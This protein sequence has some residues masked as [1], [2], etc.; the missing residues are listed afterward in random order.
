MAALTTLAISGPAT[1]DVV[2]YTVTGW[3]H[4]YPA[5]TT[6]PANAPWGVNGYPG[7]TLEMVTYTGAL[8]LT[9]GTYTLKI[10]LLEWTIDYTYGGTATDP[11]AWS[12]LTFN[13][14]AIR[15]ISF[16][17]G[18]S[19]FLSQTARLEATWENDFLTINGGPTSSFTV[20]G[21]HVDV[22]PLGL[23]EVG[24]SNFSGSN[25]WA[26]PSR[27]IMARFDVTAIPAPGAAL[28]SVIGLSILGYIRKRFA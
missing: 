24:G 4:Q 8:D 27:D 15:S 2:S 6:P 13:D 25:P 17:S 28:L 3:A 16:A 19:G 5:P 26:Q 9:P 7:D 23:P 22:T 11:N 14:T 10:N 1:A 21:F 20:G 12:D 18:P